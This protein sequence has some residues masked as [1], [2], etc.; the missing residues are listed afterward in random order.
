MNTTTN[1]N[2]LAILGLKYIRWGSKLF[3]TGLC[4][5]LIPLAHYVVGGAGRPIGEKFLEQ[6]VLW[7]G[8]PAEKA[9]QILLIGGLSLFVIGFSYSLLSRSSDRAVTKK[10]RLG[11]KLCVTG[12]IAEVL[13]G[14]VLYV[15]F[16]FLVYTNFYFEPHEPERTIWLGAQLVSFCIYFTGILLALGSVKGAVKELLPGS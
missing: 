2:E 4:L 11:L 8:C 9:V 10:E 12:L 16:D 6:V 15:V 1:L 3:I 7:F 13:S 5:E 14:A